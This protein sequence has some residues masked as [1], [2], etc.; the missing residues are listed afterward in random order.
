LNT[1]IVVGLEFGVQ[2][3]GFML[4]KQAL[5]CL[6]HTSS[7]FCFCYFR[8]RVSKTAWSDLEP[9]LAS[10]VAG[11]TGIRENNRKKYKR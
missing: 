11:I 3:Q 1:Y 9:I 5:Q 10:Q 2:T 8:D 7:P 4:E 6:N